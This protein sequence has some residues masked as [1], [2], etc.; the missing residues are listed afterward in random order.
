MEDSSV[1]DRRTVLRLTGLGLT[2][3]AGLAGT[4]ASPA[5][6]QTTTSP[7]T[8]A[9]GNAAR[10]RGID[11]TTIVT[12]SG[13][14]LGV[15]TPRGVL[16]VAAAERAMRQGLPVTA[17]DLIQ[18]RGNIAALG[19]LLAD[20]AARAPAAQFIPEAQVRFGKIVENPGKIICVGLNYA[21]HAAE[22]GS[23]PPKEPIL[24]NKYNSALNHHGGT[25]RVTGEPARNWDYEAELV[26]VMARGGRNIPEAQALDYVFGYA[27]GNDFTARD[28]QNR[29]TQWMLGKTVDGSGP[30]GPWLVSADQ[31]DVNNLDM[32]MIVNGEVRQSTNTS[33]MIFNCAQIIAYCSKHFTL[34]PGDVIFTGTCEGVIAGYPPEKR[35]WLK[36][37]DRMVTTI[38][39]IG[40]LHVTL[41]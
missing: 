28:L 18:G 9:A 13:P 7:P 38:E 6:A 34:E 5:V 2:A 27:S 12:D 4:P 25:I 33:K 39:R 19:A 22:G 31:V 14:G 11:I 8:P 30:F 36:P 20:G 1:Q 37:G 29:S 26:L 3:G 15:R 16:D 41:T 32:K 21:A 23:P 40:D 17:S 24:F 10:L 35:V